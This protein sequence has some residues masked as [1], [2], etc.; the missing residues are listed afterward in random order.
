MH[1]AYIHYTLH[2]L[3]GDKNAILFNSNLFLTT[4]QHATESLK[5][6][7]VDQFIYCCKCF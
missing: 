1:N 5:Y 3:C 2:S 4:V 6:Y 7:I